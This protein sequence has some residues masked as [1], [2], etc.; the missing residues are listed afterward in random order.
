[1]DP[2]AGELLR[3]TAGVDLL[4]EEVGD[5]LVLELDADLGAALADEADVLDQ[6]HVALG[7]DAEA[8]DL[9]VTAVPQKEQLDPRVR[10]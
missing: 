5:R 2:C 3:S 7:A 8:A 9:G 10:R 4:V 1:M 6:E